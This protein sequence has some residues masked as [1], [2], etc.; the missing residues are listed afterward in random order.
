LAADIDPFC[1]AAVAANGEANGV[2]PAFVGEDLLDRPP[3]SDVEV[4]CAGDIWYERPLAA[5]ANAW[6]RAAHDAGVRV[7]IGDPG[8]SYFDPTGLVRLAEYQ[9]PTTRELED[10]A[11]KRT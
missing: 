10:Q 2:A 7:L 1:A 3:P 9:V 5:R 6:L 4:I 11:V 8:R